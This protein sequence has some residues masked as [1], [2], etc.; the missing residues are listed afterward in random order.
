MARVRGIID[1]GLSSA[2]VAPPEQREDVPEVQDATELRKARLEALE[3]RGAGTDLMGSGLAGLG[4]GAIFGGPAGLLVAGVAHFLQKKRREGI[5]AYQLQAAESTEQFI[6]TADR[7]LRDLEAQATTDQERAEVALMRR[8]YEGLRDLANHPDPQVASTAVLRMQELTGTLETGLDEWETE[9][10]EAEA[11]ERERLASQF[12]DFDNV[13]GDLM[14]ESQNFIRAREAW[15]GAQALIANPSPTNDIALIYK[16]ANI[17]DPGAIVT[18]GDVQVLQATGGLSE[19]ATQFY[20]SVLLGETTL[21]DAQRA[22]LINT[23]DTLYR[24]QRNEQVNRNAEFQ[25]I[26]E[27]RGFDQVY[28]DRLRVPIDPSEAATLARSAPGYGGAPRRPEDIT[29][30][31]GAPVELTEE[32]P[33]FGST[34]LGNLARNTL[35][36]VQGAGRNLRGE[37]VVTSPD[38]RRYLQDGDGNIIQEL[39]RNDLFE[40]ENGRVLRLYDHGDGRMEW[41]EVTPPRVERPREP[42]LWQEGGYFDRRRQQRETNE[43]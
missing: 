27:A 43:R 31:A 22:D 38:G 42:G 36:I 17:N 5:A 41:R 21:S 20:N 39:E 15:Q 6:A 23:I 16:M 13:R 12:D 24:E 3:Q 26:G 4:A 2:R 28:Q 32:A 7:G 33:P 29:D 35:D 37:T 19:Q 40:E 34:F 11:R 9:R 8:E 1:Q 10:L 30:A 18:E 25:A 14:R